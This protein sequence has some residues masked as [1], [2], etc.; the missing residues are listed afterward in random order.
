METKDPFS[1]ATY[2]VCPNTLIEIGTEEDICSTDFINGDATL[3]LRQFS[4]VYC[5]EDGASSNNCTV[6]GGSHQ[7]KVIQAGCSTEVKKRME[8]KGFTFEAA[9]FFAV[10]A[11]FA[12][13]DLL[14]EDCIFRNISQGGVLEALGVAQQ[15]PPDITFRK[16]RFEN[17]MGTI[18]D[19]RNM[20]APDGG[21]LGGGVR[22]TITD[23]V[24]SNNKYKSDRVVRYCQVSS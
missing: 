18:D 9:D 23:S 7:V 8:V 16:C 5:G 4:R 17:N 11:I 21:L 10:F 2:I 15:P 6:R 22:L 20:F 1:F 13:G 24:F 14:L 12:E 3:T 19:G